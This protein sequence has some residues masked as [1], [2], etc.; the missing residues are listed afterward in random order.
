MIAYT[1][2]LILLVTGIMLMLLPS[3]V[4]S[5]YAASG[6]KVFVNLHHNGG[7]SARVCVSSFTENLGCKIVGISSSNPVKVGPL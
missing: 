2:R 7:G 3:S 4:I 6:L 1:R 5:T